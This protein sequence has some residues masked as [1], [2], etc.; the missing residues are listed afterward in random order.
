M[1]KR[2]QERTS[3]SGSLDV[4]PDQPL[5]KGLVPAAGDH[6]AP[7]DASILDN[8]AS[9][10]PQVVVGEDGLTQLATSLLG[11]VNEDYEPQEDLQSK[12]PAEGPKA[13]GPR[14]TGQTI[15]ET[16]LMRRRRLLDAHIFD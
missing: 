9:Q 3:P 11:P 7:K 5:S 15:S 4:G 2:Y 1:P 6:H 12:P 16:E 10:T 13:S 8:A 14:Q